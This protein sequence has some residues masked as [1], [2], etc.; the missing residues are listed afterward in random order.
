MAASLAFENEDVA[1]LLIGYL[2]PRDIARLGATSRMLHES[3]R[4]DTR[5]EK[6]YRETFRAPPLRSPCDGALSVFQLFARR[7]L[8]RAYKG[9]PAV[10][11]LTLE[12]PQQSPPP[13]LPP[14]E[15]QHP[16]AAAVAPS[17]RRH[18]TRSRGESADF[19]STLAAPEQRAAAEASEAG[20]GA[21]R[22]VHTV[23]RGGSRVALGATDQGHLA[24]WALPPRGGG[25]NPLPQP[26]AA[27]ADAFA[28]AVGAKARRDAKRKYSG[29]GARGQESKLVYFKI[30]AAAATAGPGA[31]A[32]AVPGS[33][34][35]SARKATAAAADADDGFDVWTAAEAVSPRARAAGGLAARSWSKSSAD[36]DNHD[37]NAGGL[38]AGPGRSGSAGAAVL[39][40]TDSDSDVGAEGGGL[41]VGAG[42]LSLDAWEATVRHDDDTRS[43]TSGG[44]ALSSSSRA[45][46]PGKGGKGKAGGSRKGSDAGDAPR[47]RDLWPAA[48]RARL[49]EKQA[50]AKLKAEAAESKAAA[51]R[52]R[53]AAAKA[54]VRAQARDRANSNGGTE[55]DGGAAGRVDRPTTPP[56]PTSKVAAPPSPSAARRSPGGEGAGS[57]SPSSP[58]TAP[59]L[60]AAGGA[61]GGVGALPSAEELTAALLLGM[62][63]QEGGRDGGF[64][65]G[66]SGG[67]GGDGGGGGGGGG[68]G[69]IAL[70]LPPNG[71]GVAADRVEVEEEEEEDVGDDDESE[72][73]DGEDVAEDQGGGKR[74]GASAFH[75]VRPTATSGRRG[76]SSGPGGVLDDEEEEEQGYAAAVGGGKPTSL[77]RKLERRQE[78]KERR[79]EREA[80][81]LAK[82]RGNGSPSSAKWV[83]PAPTAAAVPPPLAPGSP[84]G[85]P[86]QAAASLRSPA[87]FPTGSSPPLTGAARSKSSM[88]P[89]SPPLLALTGLRSAPADISREASGGPGPSPPLVV[90]AVPRLG[91]GGGNGMS[92]GGSGRTSPSERRTGEHGPPSASAP[93]SGA[94]SPTSTGPATSSDARPTGTRLRSDVWCPVQWVAHEPPIARRWT[95]AAAVPAPVPASLSSAA[96]GDGGGGDRGA[97]TGGAAAEE[98]RVDVSFTGLPK[99]LGSGAALTYH[100][101]LAFG[102]GSLGVLAPQSASVKPHDVVLVAASGGPRTFEIDG[103]LYLLAPRPR[104][105]ALHWRTRG[106]VWLER[107]VG[108]ERERV[109]AA[110]VCKGRHFV[111]PRGDGTPGPA[112]LPASPAMTISSS[113]A[114]SASSASSSSSASSAPSA[115]VVAS[116]VEPDVVFAAFGRVVGVWLYSDHAVRD[117]LPAKAGDEGVGVASSSSWSAAAASREGSSAAAAADRPGSPDGG[118]RVPRSTSGG[119]GGGLSSKKVQRRLLLE[120]EG[121]SSA[122]APTAAS[123]E[124]GGAGGGHQTLQPP[125]ASPTGED[126]DLVAVPFATFR[127]HSS[128]VTCVACW[129]RRRPGIAP[130]Y[131]SAAGVAQL[132]VGPVAAVSGDAG[133]EVVLWHVV[134]PPTGEAPS[135]ASP[136]APPPTTRIATLQLGK[137]GSREGVTCVSL[138]SSFIAAGGSE[139]TVAIWRRRFARGAP[140]TSPSAAGDES[141]PPPA[142][143]ELVPELIVREHRAHTIVRI[144]HTPGGRTQVAAV[145]SGGG[146]GDVRLWPVGGAP[147]QMAAGAAAATGAAA[148]PAAAQLQS[149]SSSSSSSSAAA[150]RECRVLRGHA[151]RI[152]GLHLDNTVAL[153]TSLDGALKVWDL[154][155]PHLGRLLHSSR[156]PGGREASSLHAAGTDIVVGSVDGRAFLFSFGR[157]AAAAGAGG[158]A[159]GG[160]GGGPGAGAGAGGT[161]TGSGGGSQGQRLRELRALV[162]A[163]DE[164]GLGEVLEEYSPLDLQRAYDGR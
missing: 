137:K 85:S 163:V 75:R 156:L 48:D 66:G 4:R 145:L 144:V 46:G 9:T 57:R 81:K 32:L 107:P 134:P 55:A 36:D 53:E 111:V 139:G 128:L 65:G 122:S 39:L 52:E 96:A 115:F 100:A 45:S 136:P 98:A 60:K 26:P 10:T 47:G 130:W 41:G 109:A 34:P 99:P 21:M 64:G 16:D 76:P 18:H 29:K 150:V 78:A 12:L 141:G 49:E 68:E 24:A 92:R 67:G 54:A 19:L 50:K 149:S 123:A 138:D 126:L 154:Q 2:E 38:S 116:A 22:F 8:R 87:H 113:S 105:T 40:S 133:G 83:P 118:V 17:S 129:R 127:V 42:A 93:A 74:D 91:S 58:G 152:T 79:A 62:T 153:S 95:A 37:G 7:A 143:V 121:G 84:P 13:L 148:G 157:D 124:A 5:W 77:R 88:P 142:D 20:V 71:R 1:E 140:A 28:N 119:G 51:E 155:A 3:C 72:D 135:G 164:L 108:E 146:E 11:E 80:I 89:L 56:A 35:G 86:P 27:Q 33:A 162:G 44:A 106:M 94:A 160:G 158:G 82:R 69:G 97:P 23:A 61:G 112:L 159:A 15:A 132:E 125:L 59:W 161:A 30:A 70:T 25:R 90:Q 31:A 103:S 63:R 101:L 110:A 117:L 102:D 104:N 43:D 73:D 6:V 147:P 14:P 151:S 114:S 131:W 120:G